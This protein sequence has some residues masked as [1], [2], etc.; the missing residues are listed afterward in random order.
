MRE[1]R[2]RDRDSHQ[3][4]RVKRESLFELAKE[5]APG[6]FILAVTIYAAIKGAA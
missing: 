6:L 1:V 4:D 3:G 2:K 5:M